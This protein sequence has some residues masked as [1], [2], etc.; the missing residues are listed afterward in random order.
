MEENV[1]EV[2]SEVVCDVFEKLAFMFGEV[3]DEAELP[4]TATEYVECAQRSA[5]RHLR[6]CADRHCG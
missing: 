6:Q 1:R 4:Q 3:T 2:I 5:E